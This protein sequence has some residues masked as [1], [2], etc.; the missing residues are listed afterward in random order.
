MKQRNNAPRIRERPRLAWLLIHAEVAGLLR[1]FGLSCKGGGG[2]IFFDA[3]RVI[4]VQA[5]APGQIIKP[6]FSG[7]EL[8]ALVFLIVSNG[9]KRGK[10]RPEYRPSFTVR[11]DKQVSIARA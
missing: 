6:D 7:P 5:Y 9:A 8:P 2:L 3:V 10:L 4:H 1:E 11:P